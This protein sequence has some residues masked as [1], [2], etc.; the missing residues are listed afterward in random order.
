MLEPA[1]ALALW[2]KR[3]PGRDLLVRAMG[4]RAGVRTVVDA[5]AGLGRDASVLA[6]AGF[7]V[8]ALERAPALV[9]LWERARR[10]RPI[11]GLA[12]L[13]AD[14]IAYLREVAGTERAPD[15]VYL[16]P[17]YDAGPRRGQ[18][19]KDLV[20]VREVVGGDDDVAALF[21]AARA[22]ARLRVVVKRA[23]RAPPLGAD[24]AH[25]FVGASTRFDLHLIGPGKTAAKAP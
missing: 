16:D 10:E 14:A 25:S 12:F 20:R 4:K 7:L 11:V 17:M 2:D 24:V 8:L 19:K 6:H 5:T 18:P 13:A 15:A 9:T 23:R 3:R 21:E 1:L 22:A